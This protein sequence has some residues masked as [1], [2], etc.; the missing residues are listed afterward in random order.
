MPD[1][2]VVD[3]SERSIDA[4]VAHIRELIVART[5]LS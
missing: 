4:V 1:A 2:V 3:T 5:E